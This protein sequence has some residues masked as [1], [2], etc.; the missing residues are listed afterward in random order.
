MLSQLRLH[1]E[2]AVKCLISRGHGPLVVLGTP[3]PQQ[4]VLYPLIPGQGD[5]TFTSV[6]T[7][8]LSPYEDEGAAER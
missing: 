8:V 7:T 5:A 2:K 4:I 1:S 6:L 3:Y